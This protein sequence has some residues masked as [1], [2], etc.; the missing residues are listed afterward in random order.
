MVESRVV[1]LVLT[2]T[3]SALYAL[4]FPPVRARWLA[5]VALV[6]LLVAIRDA[7]LRRRLGLGLLWTLAVGWGV[8]TWMPG[9]VSHYFHQPIA[10]G[11]G[12]FL[13]VT[14]VMAAPYYVAFAA[15]Y[16]CVVARAGAAA[17]LLTG[18]AWVAAE[19]AR[20][21]L[22]NGSIVYVGNSPWGTFGYSQAEVTSVIQIASLTGVYGVSFVLAV[23]NAAGAEI[24]L[25]LGRGRSV[26]RR[27]WLGVGLAAGALGLTLAY[28]ALV[29]RSAGRDPLVATPVPIAIAQANLD[30]ATRWNA[31]GPGRTLEAYL[32]LTHQAFDRGRPEIVFWPEVALTFFLEQEDLYGAALTSGVR[33]HDAE[34]VVGAPRAGGADGAPP[35]WN[36]VY[37]LAP[38]GTRVA[39][40]DKQYLLPFMEYSPLRVELARRRFG[41]VAAFTPGGF[42]PPLPTRAGN[43]GILICNE[44]LLP[45]LAGQRVA[46]GAVYLVNPSNDSWV[47]DAGF[48]WQ[49][50]DIAA[51]RAVEQRMYLIRVSDSGPSGVVDPLGRVV[52]HSAALTEDVLL[53]HVV[54]ARG[55]SPYARVG[56]LFGVSCAALTVLAL[57]GYLRTRRLR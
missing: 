38:D 56:D 23:V 40:Y 22:L 6:P 28:G 20:G 31:D 52:A 5:W 1:A 42:T 14:G 26:A 37:V 29:V 19:L 7:S 30:A 3:S 12:L 44:A 47:P 4:A 11:I 13:L 43:A 9:A 16:P 2:V 55:R 53:T 57:V 45:H 34:L 8:G 15:V 33:R 51:F 10:V 25:A 24:V 35:Y 18:A 48:A 27:S 50:F 17:P 36:S 21:R 46:D 32:G 41:P 54:P 49:Q 39:R